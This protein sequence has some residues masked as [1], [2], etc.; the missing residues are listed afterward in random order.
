MEFTADEVRIDKPPSDLDRLVL[1]VV[2]VLESVGVEYAVVSGYVVV[3]LGRA[4]ATEDVDVITERFDADTAGELAERLAEA[5]FW[6]PAMPLA[7]L[8]ETVANDLPVR[9]AADGHR[10]PNVELKVATDDYDRASLRE[11]RTVEFGDEQ[12]RIGSLELQIAYKLHMDTPKDFE[13]ALYLQEVA[14]PTLNTAKL[15]AHVDELDVGDAYDRLR[16]A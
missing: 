5:G 14:E 13:D 2:D 16:N 6:G 9:I 3:L 15:E 11:P 8:Y 7:D 10:V 4:R 1:D 12:L